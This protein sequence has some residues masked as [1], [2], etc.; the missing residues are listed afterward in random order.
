MEGYG[1][2]GWKGRVWKGG[3]GGGEKGGC[4]TVEREHV[5]GEEM[6]RPVVLSGQRRQGL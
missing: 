1:V 3:Q 6:D 2:E 5:E 4:G